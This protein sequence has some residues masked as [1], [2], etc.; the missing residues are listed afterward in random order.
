MRALVVYESA[1]GNT[2]KVAR[3]IQEGL[4]S[5]VPTGTVEVGGAAREFEDDV[6]LL[7]V[8]GP[9]HA[10]GMSRDSTRRDAAKKADREP[11]SKGQGIREWLAGVQGQ[12]PRLAAA[13]DTRFKKPRLITGS[14]ARGAERRLRELGCQ[15]SAPAES[16]FVAGTAGP[17]LDGELER[18]RRWGERLG[19]LVE[20]AASRA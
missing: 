9:T 20:E 8:G 12:A 17:L 6:D 14:A 4:T 19:S 18:A 13:F 15:I 1:F 2:E 7:V 5:H 16:F 10:F 11:V 3:A